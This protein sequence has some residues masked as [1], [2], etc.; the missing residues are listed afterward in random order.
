MNALS[1]I[2]NSLFAVALAM[3]ITAPSARADEKPTCEQVIKD[4][5]TIL[6]KNTSQPVNDINTLVET[7][8]EIN[9]FSRLPSRYITTRQAKD[10]GWSGKSSESLWGLKPTN[11]KYIGGDEFKGNADLKPVIWFSAD[12]DVKNGY[13]AQKHLI[14]SYDSK[15]PEKYI[16]VNNDANF[17]KISPC[18]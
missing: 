18:K 9:T 12:I 16:T 14:F 1:N 8:H 15:A 10:L 17:V 7:L 4:V 3:T 5:N 6:V 13:R 11:G 2:V